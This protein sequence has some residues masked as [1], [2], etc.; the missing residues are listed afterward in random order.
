M[1]AELKSLSGDTTIEKVMDNN[2]GSYMACFVADQVGDAKLYV[3][4][5]GLQIRGS[6]YSLIIGRNYHG[7]NFPDQIIN[8]FDIHKIPVQYTD[9]PGLGMSFTRHIAFGKDGMWAVADCIRAGV[10]IFDGQNNLLRKIHHFIVPCGVAFDNDNYFYVTDYY[11]SRVKKFS[12]NGNYLL[13][14]DNDKVKL[15]HGI[16]THNDKVY[17]AGFKSK[18]IAVFKTNGQFCF[19]FGSERLRGPTDVAVNT[20][21]QLVVVDSGIGCIFTFTLDGK[22]V[23]KFGSQGS[24]RG[25]F[26]N[27]QALAIDPNGFILVADCDNHRVSIFDKFGNYVD[28]FGSRGSNAGQFNSPKGIALSHNGSIYVSDSL[29]KRVQIFINY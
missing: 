25:Q 17:V 29:N 28:S 5:N 2:D 18:H 21:N 24:G 11:T 7:I 27:P 22:C 26:N 16:T 10:Y 15:P 4:I 12:M 9:S 1:S 14:F 23:G 6:P 3:S 8:H 13:E 20:N 19:S